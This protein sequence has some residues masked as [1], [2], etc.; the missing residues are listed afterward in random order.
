MKEHLRATARRLGL[1]RIGFTTAAA[2]R[3]DGARLAAW[4]DQGRHGAMRYLARD[5]ARRADPTALLPSARG[6][7]VAAVPYPPAEDRTVAAYARL[8]DY[9]RAIAE[10]LE[11]LAEELG[12][13]APGTESVVCVDTKPLL[14]RAAAAAAGLGWIG[15]STML[16]DV[17]RGPWTMLGALVTSAAFEP[18]PPARDRCGTCTACLDACPTDAFTSPYVLDARR[19]L[20]Y[21][22]IEHRGP[23]P[24]EI[25][26]AQGARVFGCDDCLTACP[27]GPPP[28]DEDGAPVLP[29]A[30]ELKEL[31]P[32]ET[33]RRLE[34]GFNRNFKRFAISRAG[35]AGLLRNAITAVA[36]EGGDG[37]LALC[38]RYVDHE[39]EGVRVH[40][41]WA[42]RRLEAA[43]APR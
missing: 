27:F 43:E 20:S 17:E 38:R 31:T 41:A 40:A 1:E 26:E 9:H 11:R 7:I 33:I 12:R 42:V 23:H 6:V 18:D 29:V 8:A 14:E 28:T 21:W 10:R 22:T 5:P 34:D 25:R 39:D 16:L 24:E 3:E 36:H 37:A 32:R 35:K 19:C 30:D 13:L 4:V 2:L 15:K